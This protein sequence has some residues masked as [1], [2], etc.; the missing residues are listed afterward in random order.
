V[1]TA[2]SI[3][4][5]GFI[6][7]FISKSLR[8]IFFRLPAEA[9]SAWKK[10]F[11]RQEEQTHQAAFTGVSPRSTSRFL[12]IYKYY[13]TLFGP[14]AVFLTLLSWITLE[15]AAWTMIYFFTQDNL[16]FSSTRSFVPITGVDAF[17]CRLYFAGYTFSTLGNGD[18]VP[19]VGPWQVVTILNSIS[20]AS[21]IALVVAYIVSVIPTALNIRRVSGVIA[22][23][24]TTPVM[25]LRMGWNGK[26][27]R[28]L[29]RYSMQ[30][31]SRKTPTPAAHSQR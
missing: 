28:G 18:I 23:I 27:F 7:I 24:G 15:V 16:I 25:M 22:S 6:A 13:L 3:N 20:G 9:S 5:N 29:P 30:I 2:L 19:I 8:W 26:D 21:T 10:N 17:T 4:R 1:W 11:G 14:L 31:S 12:L